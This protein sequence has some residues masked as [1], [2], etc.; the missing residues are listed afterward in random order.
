MSLSIDRITFI[1]DRTCAN[2]CTSEIEI[3]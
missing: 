1:S 3:V 2:I